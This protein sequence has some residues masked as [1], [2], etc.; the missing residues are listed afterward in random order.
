MSGF[1][2]V[3]AVLVGKSGVVNILSLPLPSLLLIF[4]LKVE[5]IG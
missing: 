4:S 2:A 1:L 5:L 3:P